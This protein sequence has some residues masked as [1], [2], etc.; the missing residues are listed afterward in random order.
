MA[1]SRIEPAVRARDRVL[2]VNGNL[3]V[4]LKA[5]GSVGHVAGV[6]N[7]LR[8]SGLQVDLATF[9]EAIGVA[10]DVRVHQLELPE[11][12]GLP[13]EGTYYRAGRDALGQLAGIA[14]HAAPDLVYQRM[15][16]A[17]YSGV[18]LSRQRGLP[19][20][21]EYNGS[22]VWIAANWGR[23]LRYAREAQLAEDAS[24]R[25]A[26]LV[27]TVSNALEDDLVRRGVEPQRI[28]AYPNG[29]DLERFAA[30]E[31]EAR[32]AVVRAGLRVPPQ[33]TVVTFVGT[34]GQWHGAEVLARA[35]VRLVAEHP[36]LLDGR[37]AF[38]F[39]GD[40]LRLPL[41]RETVAGSA[42]EPLVRFPGLVPQLETPAYL[43]AS[44]IL[45]SPHVGNSDGSPFFGSPTKLFEYMAAGKAIVASRLDQIADV[46]TPAL[47]ATALP[48]GNPAADETA[49]AVLAR[50]G[51]EVELAAALR[52]ALER[53]AWRTV[54]GAN[55]RAYAAARYTWRHHVDAIL[56]GL[57]TVGLRS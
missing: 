50:P 13:F 32:G 26:H 27:V 51:D 3:W 36:E 20:V 38:V 25:H 46:L 45:V 15:S 24:L 18:V 10:A 6:V 12:F 33:A 40:G 14:A 29:V 28:V 48:L 16:V 44:D 41:V 23:G 11:T 49:L 53:P 35:I 30:P 42:A 39:V 54:L 34:F 31:L 9:S 1:A 4:G 56:A 8:D 5:G 37:V 57:E 21:L 55:A 2:Y 47:D 22:E 19:L 17:S 43:A 7:G 52:F